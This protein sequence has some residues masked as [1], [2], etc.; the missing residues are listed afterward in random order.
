[1]S[2]DFVP[3]DPSPPCAGLHESA[4]DSLVRFVSRHPRLLV[5]TGAG[6]STGSGIPDYRDA[7]GRWKHRRPVSFADFT[8]SPATRRRYWAG[9]LVGWPRVHGARPNP[10]HD[11]L[12]RLEARGRIPTLVTQNVDGLHQKAGS[13]RVIDLHGRL[14]VV[15]CLACG[16]TLDRAD[17]Q[18]LL[19][20]WNPDFGGLPAADAPD[21]DARIEAVDHAPLRVPD[22]PE[23]GGV[24]KPGVVFFGESVPRHRVEAVERALEAVDA[25]LVVGTSL[26]VWS[27]YRFCL[28]ARALGRPIAAVNRGRTR[29]DPLLDLRVADDCAAVLP[30]LAALP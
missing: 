28:A 15:E 25:V 30:R 21:G 8:A 11:A 14:D 20:R 26:M 5:L 17:L 27:S 13:R 10:A 29:A 7:D 19:V 23:C 2:L 1:M 22:C 9:S 6:C 24:L 12:A 16:A 4:F 18:I 3:P